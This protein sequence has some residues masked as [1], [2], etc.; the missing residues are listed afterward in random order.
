MTKNNKP[1]LMFGAGKLTAS[2]WKSEAAHAGCLYRFNI[3]RLCADSGCVTQRLSASDVPDLVKLARVL[4]QVIADD[5]GICSDLRQRL[6]DLAAS[7][8]SVMGSKE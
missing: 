8:D 7:I 6:D 4:A 5:G 1:Y 3:Y 2:V